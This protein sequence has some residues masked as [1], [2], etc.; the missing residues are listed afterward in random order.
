MPD[1]QQLQANIAHRMDEVAGVK[2]A[3]W[4][5]ELSTRVT[6]VTDTESLNQATGSLARGGQ[7][8]SNGQFIWQRCAM[9][10]TWGG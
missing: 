1:W 9:K 5:V 8:E 10:K 7:K 4:L 3:G 6:I 2:A